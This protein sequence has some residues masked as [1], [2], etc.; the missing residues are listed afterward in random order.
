[1][2]LKTL[3]TFS[4]MSSIWLFICCITSSDFSTFSFPSP[5]LMVVSSIAFASSSI[6][7]LNSLTYLTILPADSAVLLDNNL[8]WSATT[9][10]PLPASPALAASTEAFKAKRLLW[11]D[12][13]LTR[14]TIASI[15]PILPLKSWTLLLIDW[16]FLDDALTALILS[17]ISTV[18]LWDTDIISWALSRIC[19]IAIE[20]FSIELSRCWLAFSICCI[21]LVCVS[22]WLSVS[23]IKVLSP[24]ISIVSLS[25]ITTGLLTCLT[26][27]SIEL[28]LS[29]YNGLLKSVASIS[30]KSPEAIL[31]IASTIRL[32]SPSGNKFSSVFF[33]NIYFHSPIYAQQRVIKYNSHF[34]ATDI[35]LQSWL[36]QNKL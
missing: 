6:L 13:F 26:A 31:S 14:S 1:M 16:I 22:T 4:L 30:L 32:T 11:L 7:S 35:L 15:L 25:R 9:A 34:P 24:R 17:F 36:T 28:S 19:P 33:L 3:S 23:L 29:A 5:R 18:T 20:M 2:S 8:T 27:L 10:K 21:D 12:T